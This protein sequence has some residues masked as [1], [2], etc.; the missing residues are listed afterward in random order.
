[1]N[2][3]DLHIHSSVSDGKFSPAEVV[4]KSAEA[5]LTVIAITDHD[6]VDGIAPALEAAKDFPRLRVIPGVEIS[7]DEPDGEVH[8]LGYFIDYSHQELL[9]T[10]EN[11]RQSRQKRAKE[12][13]AKLATLG[14]PVDWQR[15]QEIA[16]TGSI[17]RPHIAQAL[18]E[19]GYIATIKEAF[20]KY[21]AR[22]GPAYVEREKITPAEAVGLILRA[23]GL[24]VLAHPLTSND[25]ETLAAKLKESGLI[26]I[27][28]YY[29]E[30]KPEEIQRLV[31]LADKY[32]LIATGGSDYHGLDDNAETMIGGADVPVAT[33]EQLMALAEQSQASTKSRE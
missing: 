21:I 12:M 20:D 11:M 3:V 29:G 7:T 9:A 13:V 32:R 27:E 1:M 18:L 10:L 24:P 19:K 26:G 17:G 30:Y 2:E 22:G 31:G 5:G 23:K 8:V 14:L 6:N 28:V 4:R 33:A 25:P 16:G 15:V